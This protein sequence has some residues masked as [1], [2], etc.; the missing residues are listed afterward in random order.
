[1]RKLVIALTLALTLGLAAPAAGAGP[2]RFFGTISFTDPTKAELD[3]MG[4]GKVGTLR[5]NYF[6][7]A[8]QPFNPAQYPVPGWY[9]WRRYDRLIGQ[10]A[11]NGIQVLPTVYGS[12]A[13]AAR[14]AKHPPRPRNRPDFRQ[15]MRASAERYGP[16]GDFWTDP[17]LYQAAHP[18]GPVIPITDWQI[19]NEVNS[20]SFWYPRPRAAQYKP[21]LIAANLGVKSVNPNARIVI[22]GMYPTPRLKHGDGV[23]LSRYLR[24][25]HRIGGGRWY[26]VM[27]VHP[28]ALTPRH[29]M[30]TV[31]GVRRL[32]RRLRAARKWIWI[33]EVGWATSGNRTGRTI[34]YRRQALYLRRTFGMALRSRGRLRIRGVI[35]F[36]YRDRRP[37]IWYYRTG[38][39]TRNHKPK[40]SWLAFVRMTGGRPF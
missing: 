7:P 26:D 38:L 11:A 30:A 9:D 17:G 10:A 23:F 1:M 3:R 2:K 39:F 24:S 40:P 14:I 32:L 12:P 29:A 34:P 35:W 25:L 22:A 8:V 21:L 28:Y 36:S 13:W 33:T 27:A 18:G 37:R 15:F 19:W 20:P 31:I 16:G 4:R 6:W 5:I